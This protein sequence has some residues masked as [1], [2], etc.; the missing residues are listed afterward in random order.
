MTE[1]KKG[2]AARLDSI[3]R[4]F[5]LGAKVR[6]T[7][8]LCATSTGNIQSAAVN[9]GSQKRLEVDVLKLK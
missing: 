6:E 8:G 1:T 3:V 5:A 9:L 7:A 2:M 4:M